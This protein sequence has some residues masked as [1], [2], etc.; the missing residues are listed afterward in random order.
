V[1]NSD[2]PRR[3]HGTLRR[4]RPRWKPALRR[5]WRDRET[6]QVGLDPDRALLVTGLD[7]ALVE[8]VEGLTGR[9]TVEAVVT[10]AMARGASGMGTRKLLSLLADGGVLDD[11][12]AASGRH[13]LGPAEMERLR[14]DLAAHSLARGSLDGGADVLARRRRTRVAVHG[15]G[16]VGATIAS[17]VS[18]AGV[19]AVTIVDRTVTRPSDL[20]P[21]GLCAAD[22]G[23]PRADGACRAA[24]RVAP[25]T[26]VSTVRAGELA[27]RPDVAVLA[28]DD[29]PD[30]HL[31][32]AF[33]RAG[34]PH[35]VVRMRDGRAILGPFVL[36]GE[37]SC[38]RCHDLHRAARDPY[39]PTMLDH[40][41]TE[42]EAAP[43]CD[44]V[45]ATALA[46]AAVLQV[47]AY[48]D[49]LVPTCVDATV[50]MGLPVG[51]Q[52]TRTWS[53]HPACGCRWDP[54]SHPSDPRSSWSPVDATTG[55]SAVSP[56]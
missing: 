16:R 7:P 19:R 29:E 53:P 39:W 11:A 15:A 54:E 9:R 49:G 31:T 14:P 45:L 22:L 18:S 46:A 41:L 50:E 30:R 44:T 5:L 37:S 1:D 24:E 20:A 34:V 12:A 52:R 23:T 47:L 38:I 21:G 32:D 56:S 35:L 55:V 17:L 8:V 27:A 3:E 40:L 13:G 48:V 2:R 10:R 33:V 43:A 28:P 6:L 26:E 36:P 51:E 4:V 42:P 25:S